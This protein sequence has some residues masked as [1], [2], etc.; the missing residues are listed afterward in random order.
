M[1]EQED[2]FKIPVQ[3]LNKYRISKQ[4]KIWSL[5]SNRYR[6]TVIVNG[7][8]N[9]HTKFD[10]KDQSF[11][12][13]RLVAIT[14]IPNLNNYDTVNHIN[15]NK[16][17]NNLSNLEWV[18][19]K[20]NVHKSTQCTSHPREVFQ[21]KNGIVVNTFSSV[22]E[23]AFHIEL[24]R[25]AV[26]KACLGVNKTCGGFEWKYV[27]EIHNHEIVDLSQ[28][29]L[30]SGYDNYYLFQNGTVYNRM[31]KSFLKP[32]KNA[33]GYVYVTLSKNT[34]KKN[35]YIHTLIADHFIGSNRLSDRLR[36][37]HK[38]KIRHDNRLE[39]IELV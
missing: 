39:N 15:S 36:V 38:N 21:I 13:H 19:Q 10:C 27:N 22:K 16:L 26:S 11:A 25:G 29:K 3:Y 7:Y 31:R 2:L 34:I 23:A 32:I 28:G 18:T 4:G 20:E 5:I 8:E 17:D 35:N 24:S 6:K 37:N 9:L 14:F 30:I 33:A 12:V 1:N